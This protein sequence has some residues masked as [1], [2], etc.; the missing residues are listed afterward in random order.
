MSCF[1]CRFRVIKHHIGSGSNPTWVRTYQAGSLICAPC[2]FFFSF[3]AEFVLLLLTLANGKSYYIYIY[4]Y[5]C[6]CVC[7]FVFMCV[8]CRS[9]S[10]II[11]IH[12]PQTYRQILHSS[13]MTA[14]TNTHTHTHTHTHHTSRTHMYVDMYIYIYARVF[15]NGLRLSLKE[16]ISLICFPLIPPHCTE[17][18]LS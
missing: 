3:T 17:T 1:H 15:Q 5:R 13:N 11:Y 8:W 2:G 6:V 4:I 12:K 7:K 18:K 10:Y 9:V 14:R 16:D